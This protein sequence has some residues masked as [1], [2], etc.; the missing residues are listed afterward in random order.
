LFFDEELLGPIVSM[1]V[2]AT[3]CGIV[4][5]EGLCGHEDV[6]MTP[7]VR[8]MTMIVWLLGVILIVMFVVSG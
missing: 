3:L 1:V 8:A 6:K 2:V 4:V 5:I 7:A